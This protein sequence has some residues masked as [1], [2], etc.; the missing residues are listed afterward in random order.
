MNEPTEFHIKIDGGPE[1]TIKS[2]TGIYV[3]A[4]AALPAL[5][6]T[7][8]PADVEIWVPK[9]VDAGYGPYNYRLEHDIYGRPVVS[10]LIRG[11]TSTGQETSKT[12]DK[13]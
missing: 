4:V 2:Q 3:W 8:T 11:L 1:Q 13:G 7:D 12:I 9:L 6:G 5:L 10:L